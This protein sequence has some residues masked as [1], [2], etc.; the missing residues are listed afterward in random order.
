MS[1]YLNG[2]DGTEFE[3][4]LIDERMAD[5]DDSMPD[6]R[7]PDLSFRVACAEGEWEET[8]PSINLYGLHTLAEWLEAVADQRPE[9]ESVELLEINL[10]FTLEDQT[11]EEVTLR[12]GFHLEDRPEWAVMDAP[13]DEAGFITLKM[14]RES[15]RQAALTLR[16]ELRATEQ[17]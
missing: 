12:I 9:I 15:L 11:D 1:M 14:P 17:A 2:D 13:T 4:A 7:Y 16:D 6:D 3:L 5:S 10:S 8:A